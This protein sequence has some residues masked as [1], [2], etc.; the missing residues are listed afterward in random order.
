MVHRRCPSA[1]ILIRCI[2]PMSMLHVLNSLRTVCCH[3][4]D[5]WLHMQEPKATA[6]APAIQKATKTSKTKAAQ[7]PKGKDE[8]LVAGARG[9][10]GV[11]G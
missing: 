2:K 9:K 11:F 8:F 1:S 10:P 7:K 6:Q 3:S 4:I 5:G